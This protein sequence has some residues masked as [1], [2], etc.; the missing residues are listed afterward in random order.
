M[1]ICH[2]TGLC[3]T[4][5]IEFK[6]RYLENRYGKNEE[7]KVTL[8]PH[9]AYPEWIRN[10]LVETLMAA[11]KK[12]AKCEDVCHISRDQQCSNWGNCGCK[13]ATPHKS[14]SENCCG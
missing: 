5:D 7:I 1:Y 6:G 11:V 4:N 12:G 10:G 2:E 13:S 9:G 8:E 14:E 3:E